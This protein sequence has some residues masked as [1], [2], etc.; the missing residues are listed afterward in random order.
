MPRVWQAS[1]ASAYSPRG[2]LPPHSHL[3]ERRPEH[4]ERPAELRNVERRRFWREQNLA[5][6]VCTAAGTPGTWRQ[7][8]SATVTADPASG[9]FPTGYLVLNTAGGLKRNAGA[10]SWEVQLWARHLPRSTFMRRRPDM[11]EQHNGRHVMLLLL[12]SMSQ[13]TKCCWAS[14]FCFNPLSMDSIGDKDYGTS[15]EEYS[16]IRA[17]ILQFI[18]IQYTLI[19][20]SPTVIAAS[21]VLF[22]SDKPLDA[23]AE[24]WCLFSVALIVLTASLLYLAAQV[25]AKIL[26]C[27]TFLRVFYSQLQ[28][29][30]EAVTVT[31][32]TPMGL[33]SSFLPWPVIIT[34]AVLAVGATFYPAVVANALPIDWTSWQSMLLLSSW[35]FLCWVFIQLYRSGSPKQVAK[36]FESWKSYKSDLEKRPNAVK[37]RPTASE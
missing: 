5:E 27:S 22:P 25:Q 20:L 36:L 35:M 13:K 17:E 11:L 9:S 23:L 33:A 30:E 1:L 8:A 26:L 24:I 7:T 34:N 14:T 18:A 19:A 37:G 32:R 3:P 16:A 10:L 2:T 6:F 21:L 4:L 31:F 29:W 28:V 12:H 15:H